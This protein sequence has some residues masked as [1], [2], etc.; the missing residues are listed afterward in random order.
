MDITGGGG[1]VRY[2]A[3]FIWIAL[4][5]FLIILG[6]SS[7]IVFAFKIHTHSTQEAIVLE[8]AIIG[9]SGPGD[10]FLQVFTL[11]EG[12]KVALERSDGDW[13]LVRLR[14]GI[15]GWIGGKDLGRI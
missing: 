11:H 15:G 13:V 2:C 8:T 12:T 14:N 6:A 7:G 4:L 10:E 3:A 9:R 5:A 1:K